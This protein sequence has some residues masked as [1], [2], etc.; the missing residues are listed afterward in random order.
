MLNMLLGWFKVNET[1]NTI[2]S[3][4][5]CRVEKFACLIRGLVFCSGNTVMYSTEAK[6]GLQ[7]SF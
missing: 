1:P 2:Q 5:C 6:T 7:H 4:L 3:W